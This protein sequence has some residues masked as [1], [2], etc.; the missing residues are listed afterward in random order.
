MPLT[1]VVAFAQLSPVALDL[2]RHEL[3][4]RH[5]RMLRR[6]VTDPDGLLQAMAD[7]EA[8]ISGSFALAYARGESSWNPGDIDLYAN[9][10]NYYRLVDYLVHQESYEPYTKPGVKK[11]EL[12]K[13]EKREM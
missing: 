8:I 5:R 11:R 3:R 10:F 13:E 9:P 12:T 2:A 4:A 1:D 7:S 6:F